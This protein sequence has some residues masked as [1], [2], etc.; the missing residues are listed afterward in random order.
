ME[1]LQ[2]EV[3]EARKAVTIATAGHQGMDLAAVATNLLNLQSLIGNAQGSL[4][5][6]QGLQL[7]QSIHAEVQAMGVAFP[8][9]SASALAAAAVA[10]QSP[11]QGG[12]P[13]PRQPV[14]MGGPSPAAVHGSFRPPVTAEGDA[15]MPAPGPPQPDIAQLG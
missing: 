11:G 10:A 7:L 12:L 4:S 5:T 1:A 8:P 13:V 6:G 9:A 2:R 14:A 15:P 3:M